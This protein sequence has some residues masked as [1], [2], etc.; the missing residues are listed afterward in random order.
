MKYIKAFTLLILTLSLCGFANAASHEVAICNVC[1][2]ERSYSLAARNHG[3]SGTVVVINLE[4]REAKAYNVIRRKPVT[5]T[6]IPLPADVLPAIQGYHELMAAF[7]SYRAANG[8]SSYHFKREVDVQAISDLLLE[9][10][11]MSVA[12]GCGT[13]S[14]PWSY[15]LI[16]NFPFEAACDAHDICYTSNRSKSSCDDEF[17]FNMRNITFQNIPSSWWVNSSTGAMLLTL[18]LSSQAEVYYL[19]V[20]NSPTATNAY[21][22]STQYTNA[23]ECAPNA[24]LQGGGPGGFTNDSY[25]GM[26]GGSIF[27]SCELWQFPNGNGGYYYL[28]RNCS[29]YMVP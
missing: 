9:Y 21:C 12:N 25:P 11:S 20:K 18:A 22:N 7:A 1:D 10:S 26:G 14:S 24:P 6:A 23:A 4:A 5:A 17:R 13:P 8:V 28:E 3:A 27:Q 15:A 19:A 2:S 16:P 29:F